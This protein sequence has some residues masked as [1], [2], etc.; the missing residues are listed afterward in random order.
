[1]FGLRNKKPEEAPTA[2]GPLDRLGRRNSA[3]SR[4][5]VPPAASKASVLALHAA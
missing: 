5:D 4:P 1:M 2:A 3:E